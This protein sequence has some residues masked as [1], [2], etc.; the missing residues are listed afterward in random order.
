M[1]ALR[2]IGCFTM[3]LCLC[4]LQ[5]HCSGQDK[6]KPSF[7]KVSPADFTLPNSPIIDSNTSAVILSDIGSVHFIGNN[8]SWFSYVYKRQT[9]IKILNKKAFESLATVIIHLYKSGDNAEKVD[10]L[11]AST[12]NLENG[13]VV[14]TKLDKNDVFEDRLD[15]NRFV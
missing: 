3:I 5:H 8:H 12:Y 13:Q 7:G 1:T 6:P 9:R 15:K 11:L 2:P 10:N 14:E 4:L